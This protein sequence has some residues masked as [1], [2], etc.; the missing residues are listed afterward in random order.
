MMEN[1]FFQIILV[2]LVFFRF[3]PAVFDS[4]CMCLQFKRKTQSAIKTIYIYI[5]M[6]TKKTRR[7]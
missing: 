1:Y 3:K 5:Y 2:L 4:M 7:N 6:V